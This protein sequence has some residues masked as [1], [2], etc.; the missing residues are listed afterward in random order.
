M[1]TFPPELL[2]L[3]YRATLRLTLTR[4][5]VMSFNFD[6]LILFYSTFEL[7]FCFI[8][9]SL[10]LYISILLTLLISNFTSSLSLHYTLY[11]HLIS[12]YFYLFSSL[13]SPL[14]SPFLLFHFS[15]PGAVYG[16]A[17]GKKL[18]VFI[19]GEL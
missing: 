8:L 11:F 3:T 5:Q 13:I 15:L 4:D 7:N 17:A 19:D 10:P 6:I 9:S 16:P 1:L 14:V 18:I 12:P 2:Q